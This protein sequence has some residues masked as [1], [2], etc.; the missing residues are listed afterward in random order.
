MTAK[1]GLVLVDSKGRTT[2]RNYEMET[3]ALL[4][5]YVTAAGALIAALEPCTDLGLLR[6]TITINMTAEEFA[7]TAG[8]NVDTGGTASGF[9]TDGDGAKASMRIPG[10]K[11]ALV[12]E[13]GIIAITGVIATFLALFEAAGDF[14]LAKGKTISSWIKATLDK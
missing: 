11:M 3:Q 6:G 13:G 7:V 9:V 10:V 1:L 5:D 12:Q 4:A 14:T 8:A 2:A